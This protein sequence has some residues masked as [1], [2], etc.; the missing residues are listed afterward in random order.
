MTSK[1]IDHLLTLNANE[2]IEELCKPIDYA[3]LRKDIITQLLGDEEVHKKLKSAGIDVEN[4]EGLKLLISLIGISSVAFE[5]IVALPRIANA[6]ERIA[7][8]QE[9]MAYMFE[10]PDGPPMEEVSDNDS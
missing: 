3:E 2:L 5:F 7:K 1:I 10:H 8:S 6:L 4:K 9:E